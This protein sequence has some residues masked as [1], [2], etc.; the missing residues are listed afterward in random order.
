MGELNPNQKRP[1]PLKPN[2]QK[3]LL[4]DNYIK[5]KKSPN[6]EDGCRLASSLKILHHTAFYYPSNFELL[7]KRKGLQA[8]HANHKLQ[9]DL[10]LSLVFMKVGVK[11]QHSFAIEPITY[12]TTS[13]ANLMYSKILTS[14][15]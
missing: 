5:C 2:L 4:V 13:L 7:H 10:F 8:K 12:T 3:Q 9:M 15:I 6:K 1:Y 14:K 11:K